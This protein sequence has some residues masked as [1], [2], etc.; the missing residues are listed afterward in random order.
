MSIL[1][2]RYVV[3]SVPS[4][5][6]LVEKPN[7]LAGTLLS[8]VVYRIVGALDMT[9][10]GVSIEVPVTG[11]YL[12]GVHQ[13]VSSIFCSDPSY[14]L[15]T[16]PVGGSGDLFVDKINH[17]MA[18]TGSRVYGLTDVDGTHAVE[19]LN[20]NYTG[21][22]SLG[23]LTNYRQILGEN[24]GRFGGTPELTL[25][26]P[27]NGVRE[28]LS[29]TR[30][31]SNLGTGALFKAGAGLVFSGR[32]LTD[33]N[34][35]LPATGAL[36]D[37]FPSNFSSEEQLQLRGCNI[38]REGVL[39]PTD[40]GVLPNIGP[41]SPKSF[42]KGNVGILNTKK[43]L[44]STLTSEV[45]T[46]ITLAGEYYPLE[47]VFTTGNLSHISMPVNGEYEILS[48]SSVYDIIADL[49][50]ESTQG[51]IIDVKV[52]RSTDGGVT[53]SEDINHV[54][55]VVNNNV[56]PRDVAFI[57]INFTRTLNKGDRVRLE[58]ENVNSTSNIT[59]EIG[60]FFSI[61]E[62]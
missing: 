28:T 2:K 59:A 27:M 46:V 9:G 34:C 55:R 24:V 7:Q 52:T 31:L 6:I 18:G 58:V 13:G 29:I 44:E 26:G 35:D 15:F 41:D 37:F 17:L 11:L 4:D 39:S 5:T 30:G 22:S 62:E 49:T 3:P 57:P 61:R 14:T 54:T 23:E 40:S 21:C 32:F 42:F 8:N 10:T 33:I 51:N 48:G 53:F 45:E 16:S 1:S 38:T 20:C 36:L 56:G 12:E 50:L 19:A 60:S 43:Y 25:S 47:G